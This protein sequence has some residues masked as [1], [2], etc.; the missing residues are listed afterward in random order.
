MANEAWH[1]V[2][3]FFYRY[4]DSNDR[5][6]TQKPPAGVSG[7]G[8][9]RKHCA[10][11]LLDAN[12]AL[13]VPTARRRIAPAG[14]ADRCT[15]VLWISS[16][17]EQGRGDRLEEQREEALALVVDERTHLGGQ[18]EDDVEV[19]TGSARCMRACTQHACRSVCFFGQWRL[20]RE[21]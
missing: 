10:T 17:V 6:R 16:D 18:C 3:V 1:R 5:A 14:H 8:E 20:R 19:R 7:R 4:R 13:P 2:Q 12:L 9:S 21:L 11:G 15:E